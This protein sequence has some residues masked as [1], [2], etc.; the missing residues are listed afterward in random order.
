MSEYLYCTNYKSNK[1]LPVRY[2]HVLLLVS[3]DCTVQYEYHRL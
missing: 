3:V 2:V 1:V